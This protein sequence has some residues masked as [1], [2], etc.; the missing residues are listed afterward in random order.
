MRLPAGAECDRHR[1]RRLSSRGGRSALRD[2]ELQR[3]APGGVGR[4]AFHWLRSEQRPV[5]WLATILR[6]VPSDRTSAV[7]VPGM[8]AS[9]VAIW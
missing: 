5:A 9:P 8:K 3:R 6:V 2:H 1:H 7:S 4:P